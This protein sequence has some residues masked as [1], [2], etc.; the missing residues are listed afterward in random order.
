MERLVAL[1]AV[2]VLAAPE[3][4]AE[5]VT[6]LV[7]GEEAE[8]RETSGNRWKVNVPGQESH[9]DARGYPGWISGGAPTVRRQDWHPNVTVASP[10]RDGLPLGA[11]LERRDGGIFLP[12][13][14]KTGVEDHAVIPE[15]ESVRRSVIETAE[16][17]LGLPYRWGGTDSTQGTDCSGMVF[18]VMQAHGILVPRDAG[19]Q[20]DKASFKSEES[21]EM[22][23]AGDLIFFGEG[24]ITHVGIYLGDGSYISE[25]G[26]GGTVIRG[27]TE[28]PYWGF[29]R[30]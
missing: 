29:A 23:S 20:Y 28:D 14:E 3:E 5:L 2:P 21:W 27:V 4:G 12:G 25:H 19:D 10:N 17:F 9:L 15:G 30:Y 6:E 22:A 18:R 7:V 26:V 11:R 13:G 24:S 8:A 1:R 16:L